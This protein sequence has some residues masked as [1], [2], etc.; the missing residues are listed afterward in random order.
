MLEYHLF[1]IE[2]SSKAPMDFKETWRASVYVSEASSGGHTLIFEEDTTSLPTVLVVAAQPQLSSPVQAESFPVK[3]WCSV[4][5]TFHLPHPT[6]PPPQTSRRKGPGCFVGVD[7]PPPCTPT[8]ADCQARL[9]PH[10]HQQASPSHCSPRLHIPHIICF[11]K[12][13]N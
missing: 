11:T 1:H 2:G 12:P 8:E 9:K 6:L 7:F 5:A 4:L 3:W 13:F 10:G